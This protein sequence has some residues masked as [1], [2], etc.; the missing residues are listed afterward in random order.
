ME[1]VVTRIAPSPTG[2]LHVGTARSALFNYLYA[3][4]MGGKFVVRVEDT[5]KERSTNEY[6]K[7][8]LNGFKWMGL[9]HDALYKQSERAE[10][11]TEYIQKLLGK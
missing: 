3:K 9:T 5:D 11:Y 2:N 6:E 1:K 8:I 7:D 10:I 4:K